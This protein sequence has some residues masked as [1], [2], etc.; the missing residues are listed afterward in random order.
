VKVNVGQ[1]LQPEA[2]VAVPASGGALLGLPGKLIGEHRGIG[3]LRHLQVGPER[4]GRPIFAHLL[5]EVH[6]RVEGR[7]RHEDARVEVGGVRNGLED[8]RDRDRHRLVS[9]KPRHLQGLS[10]RICLAKVLLR[11]RRGQ[12]GRV[13]AV[14]GG[15]GCAPLDRKRKQVEERGPR[16]EHLIF[17]EPPPL[18]SGNG[19]RRE[20]RGDRERRILTLEFFNHRPLR[21]GHRRLA[22]VAHDPINPVRRLVEPVVAPL[23]LDVQADEQARGDA[24]GQAHDVDGRVAEV[25]AERAERHRE[26]IAEHGTSVLRN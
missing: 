17:V 15:P 26:V 23:M 9:L 8:A 21:C 11:N 6:R 18:R 22:V 14:E 12:N 1:R 24:D 19:T 2:S 25:S 7:P 5:G 20:K 13:G 16:D 3:S 4:P 10:D